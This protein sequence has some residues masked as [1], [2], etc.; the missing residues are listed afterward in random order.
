MS[1]VWGFILGVAGTLESLEIEE[2][3]WQVEYVDMKHCLPA[4]PI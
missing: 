4:Q 3:R 1:I 2:L